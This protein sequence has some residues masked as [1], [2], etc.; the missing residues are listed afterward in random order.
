MW[1]TA[2]NI[3]KADVFA[4]PVHLLSA[5]IEKSFLGNCV[6]ADWRKEQ[7]FQTND[8][9]MNL[10]GLRGPPETPYFD[11]GNLSWL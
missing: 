5:A 10:F 6:R 7:M 11:G 2:D 9:S 1:W 4:S 3:R 8:G